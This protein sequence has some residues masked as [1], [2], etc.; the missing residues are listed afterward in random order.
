MN[1]S[2]KEQILKGLHPLLRRQV[3]K[4]IFPYC[5]RDDM[6][7]LTK[8]LAAVGD[9]YDSY[10]REKNITDRMFDLSAKEYEEI[11]SRLLTEKNLIEKSIDQLLKAVEQF[12]QDPQQTSR[13][14]LYAIAEFLKKKAIHQ[15]QIEKELISA[16]EVAEKA[17]TAKSDFLST[18]SHEIRTPLNV[19][20]G[21]IHVMLEENYLD[22]QKE[23]LDILKINAENLKYLINDILDF[24]KIESGK[25]ELET[26][27]FNL[28]DLLTRIKTAHLSSAKEN[29]TSLTLDIDPD[30]PEVVLG[31]SMR[32]GQ[33]LTNLVSN[34]IKF[35]KDGNVG[36]K[37]STL[38]VNPKKAVI[39]FEITDDGIGIP[40][41]MQPSIFEPFTQAPNNPLINKVKGTGLGLSILKKL[42][43]LMDSDIHLESTVGEG[44]KFRFDLDLPIKNTSSEEIDSSILSDETVLD[45]NIHLL[46]VEDFIFNVSVVKKILKKYGLEISVAENGKEAVEMMKSNPGLYDLVLMDVRMPVMDGITATTEIRKFD[47][48]TPIVALTASTTKETINSVKDKGMNGFIA[49]PIDPTTFA[50]KIAEYLVKSKSQNHLEPQ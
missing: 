50:D 39:R 12:E 48:K 44:S 45:E 19:I 41:E 14:D 42:L 27:A 1:D 5:D 43:H 30:L 10:D 7:I 28:P 16:R 47:T 49:K 17:S 46:L 4:F 26:D 33:C 36:I 31:D 20:V 15:K 8:F 11:N 6:S 24:S 25:I 35:T 3:E 34:A 9:T 37:V 21:L 13:D 40:T 2:A 23:N 38:D 32:L 22:S 18:M 29:N